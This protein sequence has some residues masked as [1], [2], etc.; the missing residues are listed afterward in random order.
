M[1]RPMKYKK[2]IHRFS[3]LLIC[4]YWYLEGIHKEGLYIDGCLFTRKGYALMCVSWCVW[5]SR[6]KG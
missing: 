6:R 2:A 4:V 5:E 3:C 1:Q